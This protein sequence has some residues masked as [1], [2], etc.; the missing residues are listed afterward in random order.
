MIG[1]SKIEPELIL[2]RD[3]KHNEIDYEDNVTI[4]RMR[5]NLRLYNS[6]MSQTRL[7]IDLPPDTLPKNIDWDRNRLHRV[8]NN[9]NFGEGGRFYGGWWQE[10]PKEI[11]KHITV[12]GEKTVELDY[13]AMHLRMLYAKEGIDY[14]G[15]PYV[16]RTDS[17]S[18]RPLCKVIVL[19]A[20]NAESPKKAVA[21]IRKKMNFDPTLPKVKNLDQCVSDFVSFHARV[22]EY[23]F[24]GIG[25]RLQNIDSQ[26]AERVMLELTSKSIPVLP[27]HDSFICAKQ[28]RK[29]LEESMV[30]HYKE[31]VGYLP[32]ITTSE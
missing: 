32:V 30:R 12:D 1:R 27:I 28:H 3:T 16:I 14:I 17:A 11:R 22:S 31:I 9:S 8:F 15:D 19:V 25:L 29:L 21:A 13:S 20:L 23:F 5:E 10:M 6:T 7:G 4:E 24:T 2:L 26:I 18:M